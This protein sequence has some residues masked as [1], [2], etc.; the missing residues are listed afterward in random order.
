MNKLVYKNVHFK[1]TGVDET[2]H[3]IKGVFS[4]GDED[5]HDEVVNQNGWKLEEFLKNPVVL[6]AHDHYQPAIG[7]IIELGK[8]ANGDL[9][10]TIQFAY[11]EYDFAATIFK[12]Y[13]GGYMRAFSV[14]FMND[15]IEYDQAN[16]KV[17]LVENTLYEISCVNVPANAMALAYS[18]GIDMSP[19]ENHIKRINELREKG[20][21]EKKVDM[22]GMTGTTDGHKHEAQCNSEDGN[23][24]CLAAGDPSH[25][26]KIENFK[27]MEAQGHTH[28]LKKS[29]MSMMNGKALDEI[30][31]SNNNTIRNA[32][33][34]LQKVL[35][36]REANNKVSD[37]VE[38]A[39]Q[40]VGKNVQIKIINKAVRDL[41]KV[42][43]VL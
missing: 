38:H 30:S 3:T 20:V 10:G 23:G 24:K 43:S 16:D 19:V 37:K 17:T 15:I 34:A 33:G 8:D 27:V 35:E 14:G 36:V 4:T 6:F 13:A 1:T 7:K 9:A 22:S 26:H 40:V 28:T 29:D 31:N 42:K 21:M 18:K 2:N 41:L 12:L 5:R 32:I 39:T 11:D 25:T